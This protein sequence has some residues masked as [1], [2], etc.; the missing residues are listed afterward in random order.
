MDSIH[1]NEVDHIFQKLQH[2]MMGEASEPYSNKVLSYAYDPINIGEIKNPDGQGI[3][4][5]DCGDS[6]FITIKLK[7]YK[8][9]QIRFLVDGC[10]AAIACGCAVTELA[11]E[12]TPYEASKITPQEVIR[13]LDGMPVSHTH[14]A[15]LAVQAL[16]KALDDLKPFI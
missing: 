9:N 14:C 10:G 11:K 2:Y 12:K 5:G 4:K 6:I 3:V 16:Q 1:K 15:V 7:K 8:I 13:F